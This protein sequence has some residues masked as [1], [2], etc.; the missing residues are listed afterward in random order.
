MSAS[1]APSTSHTL[2]VGIA[3]VNPDCRYLY[4]NNALA[5]YHGCNF[6]TIETAK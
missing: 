3:V 1:A 2:P 5:Q 4:V 6:L